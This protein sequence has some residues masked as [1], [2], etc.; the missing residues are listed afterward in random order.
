MEER[1]QRLFAGYVLA[2][3]RQ[4]NRTGSLF[5]KR[6]RRIAIQKESQ[7]TSLIHY[8]HQNPVHH[9]FATTHVEW[10]YSSYPHL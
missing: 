1:F 6:F 5:Q 3:N 2:I 9:G 10:A 7:L 4:E 8:V